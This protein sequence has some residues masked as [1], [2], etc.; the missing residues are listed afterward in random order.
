[1]KKT[2]EISDLGDIPFAQALEIARGLSGLTYEEIA[3]RMGKGYTTIQRYFTD[4]N[5][6]PPTHL[7]PKLCSVLKNNILIEWQVVRIGGHLV[8]IEAEA[9]DGDLHA[10]IAELTKE[11]SDVLRED[12]NAML[13]LAYGVKE[14]ARMEKE[15]TD[16]ARQAEA[17]R[18]LV[19]ARR[20]HK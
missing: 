20:G 10:K 16:L 11:F 5:Y 13:D 9:S 19:K 14:L 18:R 12:G 2:V 3:E 17:V 15:L 8:F 1:M 4:P 6:N 7:I